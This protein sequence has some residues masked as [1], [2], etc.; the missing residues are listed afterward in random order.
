M[1][2]TPVK[3]TLLY[4]SRGLCAA[5]GAEAPATGSRPSPTPVR[6]GA[7]APPWRPRARRAGPRGRGAACAVGLYPAVGGARAGLLSQAGQCLR[8]VCARLSLVTG[9]SFNGEAT[10]H[11]TSLFHTSVPSDSH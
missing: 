10:T 1:A 6:A 4:P 5:Q 3:S 11:V 9:S 2:K 7:R 8:D